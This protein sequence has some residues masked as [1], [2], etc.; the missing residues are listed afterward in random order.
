METGRLL[1]DLPET[2]FPNAEPHR[3]RLTPASPTLYCKAVVFFKGYALKVGEIT[4]STL[5]LAE[6]TELDP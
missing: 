5:L 1:S 6:T 3:P 4:L 2:D